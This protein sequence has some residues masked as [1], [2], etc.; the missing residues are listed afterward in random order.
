MDVLPIDYQ[1]DS[2]ACADGDIADIVSDA[3][4]FTL[5]KLKLGKHIAVSVEHVAEVL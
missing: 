1:A 3:E 4:M 2:N 5:L